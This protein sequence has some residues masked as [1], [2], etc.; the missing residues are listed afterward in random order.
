MGWGAK[1]PTTWFLIPLRELGHVSD[2]VKS[3]PEEFMEISFVM[4]WIRKLRRMSYVVMS[5]TGL[6]KQ[7]ATG[8]F[9]GHFLVVLVV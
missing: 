9:F 6:I 5:G 1:L 7:P 3:G 8:I 4:S 2:A